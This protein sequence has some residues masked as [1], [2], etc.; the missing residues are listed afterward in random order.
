MA[1]WLGEARLAAGEVD[2]A[3]ELAEA[4]LAGA[5]AGGYAAPLGF[6]RRL[7][8]RILRAEHRLDDAAVELSGAL[9]TFT[10]SGAPFEVARTHLDLAELAHARGDHTGAATHAT[11]AA[12]GFGA[13]HVGTRSA[14][15]VAAR[16]L[17]A[18]E[19]QETCP[20]ASGAGRRGFPN[21]AATH[22]RGAHH[23]CKSSN[24]E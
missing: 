24:S 23:A 4:A 21:A 13:L 22:V 19:A 17:T 5:R 16:L 11:A 3:R 12:D 14:P 18:P 10:G 20:V 15:G 1:T 2:A 8:G 6:A 7:A 9:E